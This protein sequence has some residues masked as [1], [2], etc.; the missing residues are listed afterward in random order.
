MGAVEIVKN[1]ESN[2]RFAEP[3]APKIVGEAAKRGLICRSVVF[4]GQDTLVFA[5]PL[6]INQEEINELISILNDAIEAVETGI[7][8]AAAQ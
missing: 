1:K 3:L 4:D 8:A 2:E 7:P 6:I 5:P